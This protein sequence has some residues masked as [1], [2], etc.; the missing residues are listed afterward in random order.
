MKRSLGKIW[1]V[2]LAWVFVVLLFV[3]FIQARDFYGSNPII[4]KRLDVIEA[5]QTKEAVDMNEITLDGVSPADANLAKPRAPYSLLGGWLPLIEAPIYKT[6]QGCH[7]ADFQTR[8]EKTGN[9]RQLT[10]NYKRGDPDSC[11][12]PIQELTH[13]MYKT[14]PIPNEGC[15]QRYVEN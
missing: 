15:A 5:F 4:R 14:T 11:S 1:T 13:S 6:A 7:E 12:G 3:F 8:L 10:N 9:F 2:I